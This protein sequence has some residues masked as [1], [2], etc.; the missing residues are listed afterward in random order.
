MICLSFVIV[1][2]IITTVI[3]IVALKV[4]YHNQS[5]IL[6]SPTYFAQKSYLPPPSSLVFLCTVEIAHS[7]WA[8]IKDDCQAILATLTSWNFTRHKN[9]F[10]SLDVAEKFPTQIL[11]YI[12][13]DSE[14]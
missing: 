2:V 9:L 4:L 7:F 11:I 1:V 10:F 13:L 12:W 6:H 8:N 5:E 14:V 3:I